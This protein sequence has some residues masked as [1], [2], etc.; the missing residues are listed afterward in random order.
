MNPF[1]TSS[2][3]YFSSHVKSDVESINLGDSKQVNLDGKSIPAYRMTLIY[4]CHKAFSGER[5]FKTKVA[6]DGSLWVMRVQ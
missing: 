2:K 5:K 1:N 4:V 6:S 3:D